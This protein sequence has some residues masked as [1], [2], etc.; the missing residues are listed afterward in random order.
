[1]TRRCTAVGVRGLQEGAVE[2]V[3]CAGSMQAHEGKRMAEDRTEG[4]TEGRIEGRIEGR[5]EG[6]TRGRTEETTNLFKSSINECLRVLI[7]KTHTGMFQ[8]KTRAQECRRIRS[9]GVM[10]AKH[11]SEM[12]LLAHCEE[13]LFIHKEFGYKRI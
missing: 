7:Q 2:C 10:A 6:R 1:M 12:C 5:T 3:E 8:K 11:M 13:L 9:Y 4:R